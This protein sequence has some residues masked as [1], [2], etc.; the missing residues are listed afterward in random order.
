MIYIS[1]LLILSV[2]L[3]SSVTSIPLVLIA[4]LIGAVTL[5]KNEM[6]LLAFLAGMLL[7]MLTLKTM[8]ISSLFFVLY[9]FVIYL[10]RRKFEIE[11]LN[12][13]L[14]FSF[15]GS[16]L[17]LLFT[18]SGLSISQSIVATLISG[19]S[20]YVFQTTNKKSVRYSKYG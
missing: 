16:L 10:Y 12:F 9:V 14:A 13:V 19:V 15:I 17:Y 20:F 5:K 1:V 11:N 3:E 7:D 2:L 18:G 8:G 6:F 4:I